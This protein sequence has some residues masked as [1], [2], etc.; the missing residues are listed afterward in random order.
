MVYVVKPIG[1]VHSKGEMSEIEVLPEYMEAMDG[2][3]KGK[4][5]WLLLWFHKSDTEEKRGI[6]KVHSH[7]ET[8]Y[9]LRGVFATRSPVRPNPVAMYRRRILEIKENRIF[10]RR[11]DVY[12]STPVIDIKPNAVELDT[13]E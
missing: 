1:F 7:G 5:I 11:M 4:I 13:E 12:E 10:V 6:M 8:G 3:K 9:P 2:L